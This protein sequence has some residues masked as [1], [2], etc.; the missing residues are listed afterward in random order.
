MAGSTTYY[1]TVNTS[2]QPDPDSTPGNYNPAEDDQASVTITATAPPPT[3][4]SA[5]VR[6]TADS[7]IRQS[8]PSSDYRTSTTLRMNSKSSATA[9]ALVRFPLPAIPTGCQVSSVKLRLYAS[10]AAP[11]RT[12]RAIPIATA[13]SETSVVWNNRPGATG[14]AAST[15]SGAG[16]RQWSVTSQVNAMYTGANHGFL[17]RDANESSSGNEQLFTS[18]ENTTTSPQLIV[19]FGPN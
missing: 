9:H 18:R 3:C 7:W 12:L 16:W 15:T 1:A 14:T 11:S 19:T 2:D 8:T 13:W 5:T 10:T 6:P 4:T 17:I